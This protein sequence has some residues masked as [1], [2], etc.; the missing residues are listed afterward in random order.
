MLL[1]TGSTCSVQF[2]SH[3]IIC[4]VKETLAITALIENGHR[5]SLL[6][7]SDGINRAI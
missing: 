3:H 7:A 2:S 4:V 1:I 6:P 5:D